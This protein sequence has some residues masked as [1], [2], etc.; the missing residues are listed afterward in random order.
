MD[1]LGFLPPAPDARRE[2]GVAWVEK[3]GKCVEEGSIA[4]VEER[5]VG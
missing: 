1:A 5:G 3:G 2:G 4:L